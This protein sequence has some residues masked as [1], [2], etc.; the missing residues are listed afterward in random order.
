MAVAVKIPNRH[1]LPTPRQVGPL[2]PPTRTLFSIYQT[3][4]WRVLALKR[5]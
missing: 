4:V 3:A 1:Q 5:T 2:L